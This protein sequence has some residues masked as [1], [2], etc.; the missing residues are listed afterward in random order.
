MKEKVY[1]PKY[2]EG[3]RHLITFS[4]ATFSKN[5]HKLVVKRYTDK[6]EKDCRIQ[7]K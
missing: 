3:I 5:V 7:K 1:Q 6:I 4:G 2:L